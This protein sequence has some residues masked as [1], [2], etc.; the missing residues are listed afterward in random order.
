MTSFAPKVQSM[1]DLQ[2]IGNLLF[3]QV[4][5]HPRVNDASKITGMILSMPPEQLAPL[6]KDQ[7]LLN[8]VIEKAVDALN[9]SLLQH[10]KAHLAVTQECDNNAREAPVQWHQTNDTLTSE[11]FP[12]QDRVR[13]RIALKTAPDYANCE[14]QVWLRQP[15]LAG[16]LLAGSLSRESRFIH[17]ELQPGTFSLAIT[18]APLTRKDAPTP[19]QDTPPRHSQTSLSDRWA[20][21]EED[22]NGLPAMEDLRTQIEMRKSRAQSFLHLDKF[23]SRFF[24]FEVIA[25]KAAAEVSEFILHR[26]GEQRTII[27]QAVVEQLGIRA[28]LYLLHKTEEIQAA[29]GQLI[30]NEQRQRTAGGVFLRLIRETADLDREAADAAWLRIK[31]DGIA[32]RKQRD[33]IRRS[34][35]RSSERFKKIASPHSAEVSAKRAERF[36]DIASISAFPPLGM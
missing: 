21:E 20:D 35:L 19:M 12:V 5:A 6:S 7:S 23:H 24:E 18:L 13:I 15:W 17:A 4:Q 33:A 36:E 10:L 14:A 25:S 31:Q 34:K 26:L 3:P 27:A 16:P 30:E 11:E 2:Q 32:A 28:A 29:G 22:D 9:Q 1:E 8:S